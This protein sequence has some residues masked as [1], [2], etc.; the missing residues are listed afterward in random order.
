MWRSYRY[1]TFHRTDKQNAEMVHCLWLSCSV[2]GSNL[3]P[4]Q[5][6]DP[7][8]ILGNQMGLIGGR[9]LLWSLIFFCPQMA[10]FEACTLSPV[11]NGNKVEFNTVDFV[12]P[13]INRQQ[14]WTFNFNFVERSTLLPI[15][16][17]FHKVD[18]VEF[19][20][21]ASVYRALHRF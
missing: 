3:S 11:H 7:L 6:V 5:S 20:F 10:S 9:V 16:S 14:S 15:C 21:V 17:W 13:A 4:N 12:E 18:R 2:H 19:N 1:W 8:W